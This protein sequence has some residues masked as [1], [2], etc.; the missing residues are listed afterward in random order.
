MSMSPVVRKLAL[1]VHL[2]VSIG[3]IGA[4]I[5]YLALGTAAA[6]SRDAQTVRGAWLGM[7][8]IGWYVIAPL[9]VASLVTG[10]VMAVGT[11]WGLFRHYWVIFSLALTAIA[12]VVVLLHMPTVSSTADVARTADAAALDALGGDLAHPGIGLA[13]LLVILVLNIYK[14]QGATGYGQGEQNDRHI[15]A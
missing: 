9:A 13:V 3:W 5:A 15:D 2:T 4:A 7:E 8:I 12:T 14:P 6:T 1:A 11:R 10:L